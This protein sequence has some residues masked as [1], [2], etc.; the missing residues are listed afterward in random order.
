[1]ADEDWAFNRIAT[2]PVY[3][4]TDIDDETVANAGKD[5]KTFDVGPN[6]VFVVAGRC[7]RV[8]KF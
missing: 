7:G 3:L 6:T 2:S 8:T 5:G 1:M 4:N